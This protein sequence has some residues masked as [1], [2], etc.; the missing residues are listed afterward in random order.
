MK[1]ALTGLLVY[2]FLTGLV[3]AVH[4]STMTTNA[5]DFWLGYVDMEEISLNVTVTN[6]AGSTGNITDITFWQDDQEFGGADQAMLLGPVDIHQG[7]DGVEGISAGNWA[8]PILVDYN[9]GTGPSDSSDD[10]LIA[11]VNSPLG[12]VNATDFVNITFNLDPE[13]GNSGNYT[14]WF[15]TTDDNSDNSSGF[16]NLGLDISAPI[17]PGVVANVSSPVNSTAGDTSSLGN[18]SAEWQDEHRGL[19][20]CWFES[21]E[22]GFW[23]NHS[24]E[25]NCDG[26]AG[27]ERIEDQDHID[28]SLYPNETI[29]FK[30]HANDTAGFTNSTE[31]FCLYVDSYETEVYNQG[32]SSPDY[33]SETALLY[34][35]WRYTNGTEITS[36]SQVAEFDVNGTDYGASYD[37]GDGRWERTIAPGTLSPDY[38]EFNCLFGEDD[39]QDAFGTD[40][41]LL[42]ES[43]FHYSNAT[44]NTTDM[45]IGDAFA[46]NLYFNLTV[47]NNESSRANITGIT[48]WQ[49]DQAFGG[50]DQA[51]VIGPIEVYQGW[52]GVEGIDDA[53]TWAMPSLVDYNNGTSESDGED[54]V[55]LSINNTLGKVNASEFVN[56]TFLLNPEDANSGNYTWWFNTT[57]DSFTPSNHS[58]YFNL[59]LDVSAPTSS[60]SDWNVSSQVNST[61]GDASSIGNASADWADPLS[62]LDYCWIESNETG[63][64]ENH[65]YEDQCDGTVDY[66][67]EEDVDYFDF[68]F[69]P[70][71]TICFRSHAND[72]NGYV[73]ST[74]QSCVTTD[75]YETEV[76]DTSAALPTYY[77][78]SHDFYYKWR[79]SNG[80]EITTADYAEIEINGT[81]YGASYGG[82]QWE[83]T[84]GAHALAADYYEWDVYIEKGGH[85]DGDSALSGFRVLPTQTAI[86]ETGSSSPDEFIDEHRLWAQYLYGNGSQITTADLSLFEIDGTNYTADEHNGTHWVVT[87]EPNSLPVGN[88]SWNAYFG[89]ANHENQTYSSPADDF[90][91]SPA[92]TLLLGVG[93]Y[94]PTEFSDSIGFFAEY[95]YTNGT[96]ISDADVHEFEINGQNYTAN[97]DS[98]YYDWYV[99]I[100]PETIPVGNYTWTAYFEKANHENQTSI[101]RDFDIAYT[102]T[103]LGDVGSSSPDEY[104]DEHVL[105]ANFQYADGTNITAADVH[106]FEFDGT[107][108]TASYNGTHWVATVPA[109]S[110]AVGSYTWDI[111]FERIG[112][113]NETLTGIPFE[114]EEVETQIAN[115]DS[116]SADEY[117]ESHVLT[118]DYQYANGTDISDVDVANFTFDGVNYTASWTG[119]AWMVTLGAETVPVGTYTW[120]PHFIKANFESQSG[121]AN[122]F[123][124]N[125]TSTQ[126]ANEASTTPDE[127]DDPHVLW[128]DYQYASNSSDIPNE[129]VTVR[130]FE[131]DGTDN[132]TAVWNGSNW[133]VNLPLQS[134]AVGSHTWIPYFG[135]ANFQNLSGSANVIDVVPVATQVAGEGSSTP[136]T[137]E[138]EHIFYADYQYASNGTDISDVD[139]ANFTIGGVNYTAS[140]NSTY[141]RWQVN[142]DDT[143][144]RGDMIWT[145]HFIKAN[146]EAQSGG[147]NDFR[148]A[149]SHV[150]NVTANET[151]WVTDSGAVQVNFTVWSE[152]DKVYDV[153]DIS[154]WQEVSASDQFDIVSARLCNSTGVCTPTLGWDV[155]TLEDT[156]SDTNADRF[157]ASTAD[158]PLVVDSYAVVTLT[159]TPVTD[160]NFTWTLLTTD[161]I[162]ETYQSTTSLALDI[163]APSLSGVLPGDGYTAANEDEQ[164]NFS[165][166]STDAGSGLDYLIISANNSDDGSWENFSLVSGGLLQPGAWNSSNNYSTSTGEDLESARNVTWYFWAND[167]AAN[168]IS[169]AQRYFYVTNRAPNA[170]AVTAVSPTDGQYTADNTP[171][172]DWSDATDLD[173]DDLNYS[174]TVCN[175]TPHCYDFYDIDA[176]TYSVGDALQDG[177]WEW[178]VTAHDNHTDSPYQ[179]S[180]SS[181]VFTFVVDAS[182]PMAMDSLLT[183]GTYMP[184]CDI[185]TTVG[186]GY[187][188]ALS[189]VDTVKLYYDDGTGWTSVDLNESSGAYTYD[190]S[191]DAGD[192]VDYYFWANDTLGNANSTDQ[193]YFY[194]TAAYNGANRYETIQRA[195]DA[196]NDGDTVYVC[197]GT[198]TEALQFKSADTTLESEAGRGATTIAPSGAITF[199][200]PNGQNSAGSTLREFTVAGSTDPLVYIGIQNITIENCILDQN[201]AGAD[202]IYVQ[203]GGSNL[204]VSENVFTYGGIAVNLNPGAGVYGDVT[205]YSNQFTADDTS[206][207]AVL[208]GAVDGFNMSYNLFQG[209]SVQFNL[210]SD[211]DTNDLTIERN[212]FRGPDSGAMRFTD[213]SA[214]A[215]ESLANLTLRY[216]RFVNNTYGILFNSDLEADDVDN[217]TLALSYNNFI[218]A[219]YGGGGT[220]LGI[221]MPVAEDI[222]A[223]YCF[224]GNSTGPTHASNPDGGGTE[225]SDNVL[226]EPYFLEPGRAT[227]ADSQAFI[228]GD[229][230][231]TNTTELV[232]ADSSVSANIRIPSNVTNATLHVGGMADYDEETGDFNVTLGGEI[233]MTSE[234]SI[235]G[236]AR[237]VEVQMPAG[238]RI[239]GNTRGS[240]ALNVPQVKERSS[241]SPTPSS[242]KTASTSSVIEVGMGLEP[243]YFDK[244]V[245]IRIA[246]QAGKRAGYSRDGSFYKITDICAN[247][248]QV[249]GDLLPA[250]GDCKMDSADGND[251]IIW[252][253]HFT[254]FV[255]YTESDIEEE[256]EEEEEEDDSYG[257]WVSET[258]G[259]TDVGDYSLSVSAPSRVRTFIG[260][261]KEFSV[262]VENTG[263][264]DLTD[265]YVSLTM[266]WGDSRFEVEADGVAGWD[267]ETSNEL[268]LAAGDEQLYL[269]TIDPPETGEHV[270]YVMA[271]SDEVGDEATGQVIAIVHE[272][273]EEMVE[274]EVEEEEAEPTPPAPTEP[275]P[276]VTPSDLGILGSYISSLEGEVSAEGQALLGEAEQLYQQALNAYQAGDY[277]QAKALHDQAKAKADQAKAAKAAA[278]IGDWMPMLAVVLLLALLGWL[279]M[280]GK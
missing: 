263:G 5:T 182:P 76:Y 113:E 240:L 276:A 235:G 254:E 147:S 63:V 265:V 278:G 241:V 164:F 33:E 177:P 82:S 83:A 98:N 192:R 132:Y 203:T 36:T 125:P 13:D 266:P 145:P 220:D 112:Y 155:S 251:L 106:E 169:S 90:D 165:V 237:E 123:T 213:I 99:E 62:G 150:S 183:N 32:S 223:T 264:D 61:A 102:T 229:Y 188:D 232:I 158:S 166:V 118:A 111:Y 27:Y 64:W 136:D 233:N 96:G 73:G 214:G 255:T 77:N 31:Q 101:P 270:I 95:N 54:R 114:I 19:D 11:S 180:S 15:N 160:G 242:G 205:I 65:S 21:N 189:S 208:V 217:D 18:I 221:Y 128:A 206:S 224:W 162:G 8:D 186:M 163:N 88:Y 275:T 245:R 23:D 29:C 25:D 244:A 58:G 243:V 126:V 3:A 143:L 252:T 85:Q 134:L 153:Y 207:T 67:R 225:I 271:G 120:T 79:Y 178:N 267:Y 71:S 121:A 280:R 138:E 116:S 117:S 60:R 159:L 156:N 109:N 184:P 81:D 97:W 86:G 72:T 273:E 215:T 130:E 219:S 91:V 210:V 195:L 175:S 269:V 100:G 46:E 1:R 51:Q 139:V 197:P 74:A 154:L 202:A 39:H 194:F 167:S 170:S 84:V 12:K 250:D 38:Y 257:P 47:W 50:T 24:Y 7:W 168:S 277:D 92:S 173:E 174:L 48:F 193:A 49:D 22:T 133:V 119:S 262:V 161:S 187:G 227:M 190:I 191:A 274:A 105:H 222:N 201:N 57:G 59:A 218:N 115:E 157:N 52:D 108:Y 94:Q 127:Y 26:L 129:T 110:K 45:W 9:N 176:S 259:V 6:E 148:V 239:S 140:W 10:R 28:F 196:A 226:Y 41:P 230:N 234:V 131:V 268:D 55:I 261:P 256:E 171:T 89:L 279:F 4:T 93:E 80:T 2:V 236:Q 56:I 53:D 247:D 249:A 40:M 246:G 141:D 142:I 78:E 258:E 146:F 185:S 30:S 137:F 135:R 231:V 209:T 75:P 87:V 66:E 14:W 204:T 70:N 149:Y 152:P 103:Q 44:V 172:L 198:Y 272:T 35:N 179:N 248:T 144:A 20:Y 42:I 122:S 34:A 212:E 16:F 43:D 124:V 253:K 211:G 68:S 107:N 260:E 151:S 104:D 181:S 200:A 199:P 238:V 37:S 228:S 17:S 69:Y 216:N